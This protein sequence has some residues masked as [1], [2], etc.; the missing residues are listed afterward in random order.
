VWKNRP[1]QKGLGTGF[2][3]GALLLQ[4]MINAQ[5]SGLEQQD[6]TAAP[7]AEVQLTA[8]MVRER[9]E[10]LHLQVYDKGINLYDQE[11]VNKAVAEASDAARKEAAAAKPEQVTVFITAGM[12]ARNVADYLFRSGVVADKAGFE[13]A[14]S[15]N[16][17]T[18]KIRTGL[19]TFS[20]NHDVPD[21]L[22]QLTTPPPL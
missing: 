4:L 17:L 15:Q 14:L 7:P 8:Q 20:L 1:F 6:D 21:I 3:A 22:A 19:Y 10:S 5:G 16:Q 2:I 18:V 11:Y 13:Q 9:A 12:S